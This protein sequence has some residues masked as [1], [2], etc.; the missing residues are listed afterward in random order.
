[1][2]RGAPPS[3]GEIRYSDEEVSRIT[4]AAKNELDAQAGL[5]NEAR[6]GAMARLRSLDDLETVHGA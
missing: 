3:Y 4:V 2:P 5:L 1:M 6:E